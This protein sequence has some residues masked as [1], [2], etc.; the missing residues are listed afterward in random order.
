MHSMNGSCRELAVLSLRAKRRT[1][2]PGLRH[3][4]D[5][6]DW[7]LVHARLLDWFV[8]SAMTVC[9]LAMTSRMV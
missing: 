8:A 3:K 6:R 5:S 9:A 7:R 4:R 1:P 2:V